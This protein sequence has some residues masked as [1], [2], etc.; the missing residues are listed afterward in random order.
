MKPLALM[1]CALL[2]IS[3]S[4]RIPV[5][6]TG[7]LMV[8]S[9]ER[10][11]NAGDAEAVVTSWLS[12]GLSLDSAKSG[13]LS[14][15]LLARAPLLDASKKA[16]GVILPDRSRVTVIAATAW[17]QEGRSFRRWYT[18]RAGSPGSEREGLLDSS[19]VALITVESGDVA[20]GFLER[21]IAVAGGESLY[22]VLAISD[23]GAVTLIDTSA[24]V[25]PESFHPSGVARIAIEDMNDDGIP[26]VVVDADTIVSLQFLGASPLRWQAWLQERKTGWAVILRVNESYGTD[27]GNSYKAE[28]R[29]FSSSGSGFKDTVK[30]T[31]FAVET[32]AQ[33][34]FRNT[35]ESFYSWNGSSYAADASKE[36][37][38]EGK[39]VGSA[40]MTA[41]PGTGAAVETLKDGDRV[42][43]FDRS[44]TGLWYHVVSTSEKEGWIQAGRLTLSR[45]DP[46]K[47]NRQSF[48]GRSPFSPLSPL[49]PLSP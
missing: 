2:F 16:T 14:G 5:E 27:Q 48:L 10:V 13:V 20:A 39:M 38:Q 23:K 29:V 42:Y 43:V 45:I 11:M 1:A 44:D 17:E 3:C 40:D 46:L 41:G 15:L 25:F 31:T 32:T 49:S 7:V 24:L 33:G 8:P 37:P 34:E 30:V 47:E 6:P 21:K 28:A 22:N 26:E 4:P 12:L 19:L 18:V 35:M 36:L 9:R